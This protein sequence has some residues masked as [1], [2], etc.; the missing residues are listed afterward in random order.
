MDFIGVL[1]MEKQD[2]I[3]T[4]YQNDGT[5]AYGIGRKHPSQSKKVDLKIN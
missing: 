1:N 2:H 3:T 5:L 4:K